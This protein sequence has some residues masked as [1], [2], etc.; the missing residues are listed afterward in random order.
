MLTQRAKHI[1]SNIVKT[2]SFLPLFMMFFAA[3]QANA[4][5]IKYVQTPN[6]ADIFIPLTAITDY[7]VENKDNTVLISFSQPVAENLSE[8][9]KNLSDFVQSQK[10]AAD[11][12][13]IELEMK[14]PYTIRTTN[15]NGNLQIEILRQLQSSTRNA[16]KSNLIMLDYGQHDGYDRLSFAYGNKPNYAVRTD[17]ENTIISFLSP[18][19]FTW[20]KIRNTDIFPYIEQFANKLGGTDIKV[21]N[22][23]LKSFE[24]NN[25]IV[26]DIEPKGQ[27]ATKDE[28]ILSSQNIVT[29]NTQ[30]AYANSDDNK[31]EIPTKNEV[32]SLAFPWNMEVGVSVFQRGK[33][34][35]VAFDHQRN[36]DL[37]DLRNQSKKVADQI[38]QLPHSKAT[39][40]RITPKKNVRVGLRQEGLLW[41][42]DLYTHNIDYKVKE[43]PIFV[44][45]NSMNQSYLYIP[46][47]NSGN[48]LSIID[49]EVGDMILIG[50]ETELGLAIDE[51]YHYQ[52][53]EILP[54]KQGFAIVPNASD[55]MM[56]KGNTGFG[57][58][59]D[60]RSLNISDNLDN[61][62]RQQQFLQ[63][64]SDVFDLDIPAQLL[65]LNF[66]DA[67]KQI[68]EDIAKAKPEQRIHAK[69]LLT[70]Y[71]LGMGLGTEAAQT[72]KLLS[73]EE[74]RQ[75]NP[76]TLA[77][78]S[79]V[80]NFL[81]RRYDEAL[82][83]FSYQGLE[84]NNEAIFWRALTDSALE[85]KKEN[86]IV[87]L[88]FI[89]IIRDYPQEL[90]ERIALVAA[91][92]SIKAYDDISTQ[93]FLDILKISKENDARRA[94]ILY[95]NAQKFEYQ[96]Y[97]NNALKEYAFATT[98]KSQKYASLARYARV[99]LES[100]LNLISPKKAIEEL[101][102]LRF[103]WGEQTFKFNL[104]QRLA[105]I[106]ETDKNYQ[107]ALLTYQQSIE[108]AQSAS[109]KD[110]VL[111][112]MMKLFEDLYMNGR[113]DELQ[114]VKAIALYKDYEWLAPRSRYYTEM[115]QKLADRMVAVDLLTSASDILKSQLRLV[116]LT[117][118]QR[119]QIGAR[120]ALIY[121]FEDDSIAALDILQET[122][123]SELSPNQKQYRKII[124]AKA[125]AYLKQTKEALDFLEDDYSKNAL[126]LKTDI[127]WKSAQWDKAA[128]TIK[129]LIEKPQKGKALSS[130]QMSYILDWITA[131]KKA[132]RNTVI[133]RIR[134]TFLPYFENTPFYSTFSVLTSNLETNR[135]DMNA[136]DKAVSDIS[137][138]SNFSK[139]YDESLLKTM[140]QQPKR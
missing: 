105:A 85:F 35:W 17:K 131:L 34:I 26:L 137:A 124:K 83:D 74:R 108:F 117:P 42:I 25:K 93:N 5:E 12:H 61:I 6:K 48:S 123:T 103:A 82:D 19:E 90:K 129:Y 58:K 89:A 31:K 66:L 70:R 21:P 49:P 120:L 100:K 23:L 111:E 138:Y 47:T 96:G 87:L 69:L 132:N 77:A 64:S 101:E 29:Q 15:V 14:V 20:E 86:D 38:I 54:A 98:H 112:K 18:V 125:L 79:G 92:T 2:M 28:S 113:A 133:F 95:L 73:P 71:Y 135:V 68:K 88:T 91:D 1:L 11:K 4:A 45:Y 56:S 50:T 75:V 7:E 13:S 127:Y 53:L 81:M 106:Y 57:I 128:D 39:I 140:P 94:Q 72:L 134:N 109:Q 107:K 22:K 43:L 3:F 40:L 84:K 10:I 97:P 62:K 136:I 115:A 130:E 8:L 118:E 46:S 16:N 99:N 37:D 33:Y 30:M 139:I 52:D 78:L 76:K 44:Q 119:A 60:N 67:E 59:A 55:I 32:A 51:D 36:I 9:Q 116:N 80:A 27:T 121:L 63:K 41:I 122:E 114:A 126:L 110:E 104:L 24:F 65:K 102:R